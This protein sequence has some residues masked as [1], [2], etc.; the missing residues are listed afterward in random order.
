MRWIGFCLIFSTYTT[1]GVQSATAQTESATQTGT[2][3]SEQTAALTRQLLQVGLTPGSENYRR[4]EQI[5]RQNR[6]ASAKDARLDFAW[7]L[8]LRKHSKNRE[9]ERQFV[10]AI[11][12]T[13][14][15]YLP[16]QQAA[17]WM[18]LARGQTSSGLALID[19]LIPEL[20]QQLDAPTEQAL[21]AAHWTGRVL[22]ALDELTPSKRDQARIQTTRKL[23]TQQLTGKLKDAYDSGHKELQEHI[24]TLQIQTAQ[25]EDQEQKKQDKASTQRAEELKSKKDT[26]G[27]QQEKLKLTA[28]E[29]K[30]K[31]AQQTE[32]TKTQLRQLMNDHQVVERQRNLVSQSILLAQRERNTVIT[33]LRSSTQNNGTNR[34]NSANTSYLNSQAV[35]QIEQ[36]IINYNNRYFGL[37][38]QMNSLQQSAALAIRNYQGIVKQYE[39]ATGQIVRKNTDLTKL[40]SQVER[41][42]S[43]LEKTKQKKAG[44]ANRAVG[45]LRRFSTYVDFDIT[46]EQ[47]RL[48]KS[49][50][51][52]MAP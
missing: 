33:V 20:A 1:C 17:A 42:K 29:W 4:A 31:L 18:R 25:V 49:L 15:P 10:T 36:R 50:P 22:A 46:A 11:G 28:E 34:N 40:E 3:K 39:N 13:K 48:L 30:A 8:I 24:K 35:R 6:L 19:K 37:T 26:I 23:A 9:A 14:P 44:G 51:T 52:S 2:G 21:A 41:Q 5:W 7:G 32:A 45:R 16:A 12:R 38:R 43:K 47:E 27:K